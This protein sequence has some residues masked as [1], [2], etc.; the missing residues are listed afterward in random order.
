MI[1]RRERLEAAIAGEK[2]DRPPVALWRHFPVDDQEPALLAEATSAFQQTYDFDL[3]KVTPA[4][5]FCL[6]D[7]GAEDAWRGNPEGT[8]E[9]TRRPIQDPGDWHKLGV[10]DASAGSLGAQLECLRMLGRS[11]DD[12]VPIVQTIFNP[13]AQAKNLAGGERLL[14]HL[15]SNPTDVEAGLETITRTTIAF[16]EA[17][18]E[19][20]IAGIFYAIQHAS[21]QI[22]DRQAYGRFGEPYD[23]RILEAA[24]DL[25]LNVLHLHGQ[26]LIFDL[27]ERLPAHVVNW[28]DR[29][30]GPSLAQARGIVPGAV[31]GGLRREQTLVL[32]DPGTVRAE[33]QDAL[34][35][36]NGRGVILGS[37]CV[38]PVLAPRS[39]LMAARTAVDFA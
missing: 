34:D 16:V 10:L 29:D 26:A 28:H 8:R 25:W 20:G 14:K 18:F 2:A 39:N 1:S 33:A 30:E 19:E 24:Q 9:Y 37:G 36:V 21:D 27:V 35:S 22:M 3:V 15:Q 32:G 4:S 31:C 11:L 7:W 5:S 23:Q 38:V 6:L 17:A 12:G 13:L